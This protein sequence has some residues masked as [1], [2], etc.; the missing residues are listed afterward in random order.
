MI[1]PFRIILDYIFPRR[2]ICCNTP[3]YSEAFCCEECERFLPFPENACP[4]CGKEIC[5]CGK[6]H[7]YF[8]A[9]AAA[10]NYELGAENAIKEF[11]FHERISYVKPLAVYLYERLIQTDFVERIDLIIPAPMT[12][13]DVNRRG[14]NQS[15]LL[16]KELS[17]MSEIPVCCNLLVKVKQTH[18]QHHLNQAG[19]QKNLTGAFRVTDSSAIRGKTVL[20]CDDVY[21]TGSTFNEL[22]QTLLENGAAEIFCLAVASTQKDEA[23]MQ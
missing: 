17:R 5:I 15:E 13:K 1:N 10:F 8:T 23:K 6:Q 2:C 21:T 11:K 7:F 3:I 12:K 20:L 22:S 4:I 14:Y 18:K 9:V 19:R 16:A